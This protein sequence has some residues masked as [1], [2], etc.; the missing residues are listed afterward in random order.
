MNHTDIQYSPMEDLVGNLTGQN[1]SFEGTNKIGLFLTAT[2][3]DVYT[4]TRLLLKFPP[5]LDWSLVF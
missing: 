5:L 2:L 3:T 1:V 4:T